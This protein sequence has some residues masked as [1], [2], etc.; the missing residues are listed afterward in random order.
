MSDALIQEALMGWN[1]E[2]FLFF[3]LVFVALAHSSHFSSTGSTAFLGQSNINPSELANQV[4][5][6]REEWLLNKSDSSIRLAISRSYKWQLDSYFIVLAE[7]LARSPEIF[8]S[9]CHL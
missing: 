2:I 8:T 1:L 6:L 3:S 5:V 4:I 7:V 9:P